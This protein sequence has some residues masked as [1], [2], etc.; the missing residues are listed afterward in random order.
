MTT[1]STPRKAGPLNGNGSTTAFPFTFKVFATSDVKVVIANSANVETVLVLNTDYS[2]SLNANQETSPGGTV[3]YPISGSPLPSGSVLSIIGNLD[4]SQP[5][6]LPSGGNFSP[7]A[8]ENQLDRTTIQI[9]QLKEQ[10]DRSAKLPVTYDDADLE[11]FTEDIVRLADSAD[12][13]DT[14]A[15]NIAAVNTVASDLNEPVSEINTVATSI[16]NVNTVGNNITNVNTVAGISANVTTVA[17]I[18]ANV[19]T[20]AGIAANVTAVAGNATNI[21]TV[22]GN[23]ANVTAVGANITNVNTVAA[24]EV[25]IDTVAGIASNVSAVAA[26]DDAVSIAAANVDDINNFADVYQGGKTADPTVRNDGSALQSGDLYFNTT[27]GRMRIRVFGVWDDAVSNAGSV[28]VESFS[29]TGSQTVFTL[30]TD[31][32]DKSNT[33]VFIAGVYQQKSEYSVLGTTLTFTAAPPAGTSNIEVVIA[34]PVAFGNLSAIQADV[35]TKSTTATTQ[36]GIATT[37]AGIATT[38]AGI[39]TTQAGIAT[40]QAG[41]ATAQAVTATSAKTASESA[42]DAAF[43][44][45]NVYASTAAGL[46]ATT[47]GQQFQVVSG[48]EIIRYTRT[49]STTATEVARYPAA[50]AVQKPAWTGT[51]S[52]WPDPFFKA[53]AIGE[54]FLGRN[55]WFDTTANNTLVASTVFPGCR[56]LRRTSPVGSNLGGPRLWLDEIGAVPGDTMTFCAVMTSTGPWAWFAV[57]F[58]NESGSSITA[59]EIATPFVTT[60][61]PALV[62]LTTIVPADATAARVYFFN[63]GVDIAGTFDCHAFWACKGTAEEVPAW[64]N[65]GTDLVGSELAQRINAV[66]LP[67][68]TS[69]LGLLETTNAYAFQTTGA[70][71]P[72]PTSGD[73]TLAVSSVLSNAAYG[74]PFRG[75]GERY[76]PAGVTFNSLRFRSIGRLNTVAAADQWRTVRVVVRARTG[77]NSAQSGSTL[78][79]VGSTLVN[80]SSA[81]LEDVTVILRDPA[82][83]AVKTLTDADLGTEYFI[84]TYFVDAGG[85]DAFGSPHRGTMANA[86]GT[87]QSYYITTGNPETGSWT[88]FTGNFRLGCDHLLLTSP[89]DAVNYQPTPELISDIAGGLEVSP[90]T[91][92]REALRQ[93]SK[94]LTSGEAITIAMLGDSWTN[95]AYRLHTPLR[96]RFSAALGISAP[97]YIS[98]N[99]GLAVVTNGTRTRTGTWTNVN[100][101]TTAVGPDNAHA[102]TTD[103]AAQL[104]FGATTTIAKHFLHYLRQPNGGTFRYSVGGGATINVDTN[105]SLAYQVL[106][107]NGPGTLN[108]SIVSAGSAGVL[109]CGDDIRNATAGQVVLHKLGSG[110]ARAS[111][112]AGMGAGYLEAAYQSIAP[113]V[114]AICLGTN[115]HAGSVGLAAFRSDIATI[116]NRVRA[117]VPLADILLLGPGPNGNTGAFLITDY[118]TQMYSL[119]AELDCA[120]VDL[121]SGFGS[122]SEALARGLYEDASHPNQP[123]GLIIGRT[124]WRAMFTE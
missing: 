63:S 116:V 96:T 75:W 38:Q 49:N 107:I 111:H 67:A 20:V 112:Y 94:R 32:L 11:A 91:Y 77:G 110:G 31:P 22:A 74:T 24:N 83:N 58:L 89:Q 30:A 102:S 27:L 51:K 69:R 115:D 33:Q 119:A 39:A 46:A 60:S 95:T 41:V 40:T 85:G 98:A 23:N 108:I 97:G 88:T 34:T 99:T 109:I 17:G 7:L 4:Y 12:N 10:V 76:T 122:Y 50:S 14:V 114:V 5:L 124:I 26:I 13:L 100:S 68:L 1:P 81:V 19:T 64:P 104:A 93:Y 70:V 2:V 72:A 42:R 123:G 28:V 52:A 3:T 101:A 61:T 120:F 43:V 90:N 36:A 57:R 25:S 79:A 92:N 65:F 117:N 62:R 84:G 8:L 35:T 56:A 105:G 37:Q 16:A 48:I 59:Q 87:P 71:S 86:I 78:V 54:T 9:Q 103:A 18:N 55:R 45:A 73:V 47:D 113:D 29:G 80:P 15:G 106:E 6:D 66:E 21:N 44:N 121:L 53:Y 118:I 82:T